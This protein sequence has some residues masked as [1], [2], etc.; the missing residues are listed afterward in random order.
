MPSAL[1]LACSSPL[2]TLL[3]SAGTYTTAL[4]PVEGRAEALVGVLPGGPSGLP[5]VRIDALLHGRGRQRRLRIEVGAR[6]G[7]VVIE[8]GEARP[9]LAALALVPDVGDAPRRDALAL[10]RVPAVRRVDGGG[11]LVVVEGG[12]GERRWE[13]NALQG[14][15]VGWDAVGLCNAPGVRREGDAV[16]DVVDRGGD[17]GGGCRV[18]VTVEVLADVDTDLIG[19]AFEVGD[20]RVVVEGGDV[21]VEGLHCRVVVDA[22][23][24]LH[25]YAYQGADDVLGDVERAAV[26]SV[27]GGDEVRVCHGTVVYKP[28][29]ETY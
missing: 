22:V 11:E 25:R 8:R 7:V 16:A 29:A 12:V 27:T 28:G 23:A 18:S 5:L 6:P 13:V 9:R 20:G 19:D 4:L 24:D 17:S 3:R 14:L 26:H 2:S 15:P 10:R 21:N 1:L